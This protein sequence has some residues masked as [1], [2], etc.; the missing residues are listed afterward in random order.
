MEK[1][2]MAVNYT[3]SFISENR[4]NELGY[5][6]GDYM[7]N[8]T[9]KTPGFMRWVSSLRNNEIEQVKEVLVRFRAYGNIKMNY[10]VRNSQEKKRR[11]RPPKNAE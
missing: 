4:L 10:L 3:D 8:P 6:V 9:R 2:A 1:T 5:I 11:G 7:T